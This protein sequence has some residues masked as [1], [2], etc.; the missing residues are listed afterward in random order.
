MLEVTR[1][2]YEYLLKDENRGSKVVV[3]VGGVTT[4][5][6]VNGGDAFCNH[7]N[8]GGDGEY[9][10]ELSLQLIGEVKV[11]EE[12][13]IPQPTPKGRK[14][15][16][17][18]VS[19]PSRITKGNAYKLI[20]SSKDGKLVVVIEDTGSTKV[21][22]KSW[23][24]EIT[25]YDEGEDELTFR[26]TNFK[27]GD[28][29]DLRKHTPEQIRHIA[30]FYKFYDVDDLLNSRLYNSVVYSGISGF[31]GEMRV[32][33]EMCCGKE[34]TYNDIFYKEGV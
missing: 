12:Y 19:S 21:Y 6:A 22:H 23:F 4:E 27:E 18:R 31:V 16:I 2:Q 14:V 15:L 29:L 9:K 33:N 20:E 26:D 24:Q 1:E 28:C 17:A 30:K 7:I 25:L 3:D 32:P 34:Y 5:Y 10:F 13:K 11:D 8:I